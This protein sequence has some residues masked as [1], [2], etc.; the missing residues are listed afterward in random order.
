MKL[1]IELEKT[2][3]NL[4]AKN[5][6]LINQ[7]SRNFGK[8]Q[9][10]LPNFKLP[11]IVQNKGA[12]G[13][14]ALMG[15]QTDILGMDALYEAGMTQGQLD[16]GKGGGILKKTLSSATKSYGPKHTRPV[17]NKLAQIDEEGA[18]QA[19]PPPISEDDLN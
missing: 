5:E 8:T 19:D 2:Y 16:T 18:Y 7:M 1:K 10:D 6:L 12:A 13:R 11:E 17:K 3:A 15:M 9:Q 14:Q 4:E